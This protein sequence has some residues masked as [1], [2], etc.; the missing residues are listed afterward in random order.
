[1]GVDAIEVVYEYRK[2]SKVITK[3]IDASTK[4]EIIERTEV[5]YK[6]GERYTTTP[7]DKAEYIL[8]KEPTN[9]EGIVGRNDI[10][11]V[12]E[13]RKMSSGLI[14]KYIDYVSNEMLDEE[15]YEGNENDKIKL[16]I[17]EF[18]GYAIYIKP[19]KEEVSLT[20]TLQE[21]KIYYRK[22]VKLQII[23][24]DETTKEE[25][26]REEKEGIEGDTYKTEGREIGG[27]IL[28]REPDN[29]KGVYLRSKTEVI[30]GYRK[31]S[32]GVKVTYIDRE[33]GEI[34][35]EERINGLEGESYS[36]E[37]KEFDKYEYKDSEGNI[38]G[39]F[40]KELIEV[41]CYYEKKKGKVEVVYEDEEGNEIFKEELIG[42]VG[43][44]YKVEE[45]NIRN[46]SIKTRPEVTEGEYKVE[47]ITVKYI[48]TRLKGKVTVRI[49]DE[50][51][52]EL[53]RIEQ[54]GYAGDICYI[55]LP[56]YELYENTEEDQISI[57][58]T[59]SEIVIEVIYKKIEKQIKPV[60]PTNPSNPEKPNEPDRP[61]RRPYPLPDTSDINLWL[62]VKI[63]VISILVIALIVYIIRK[64]NK[65]KNKKTKK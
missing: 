60:D 15:I 21:V 62:Y 23:G 34:L 58:Y 19:N 27:Y 37:I 33:T 28:E 26:Y 51:G 35:G 1:M 7:Q 48:L 18:E 61:I 56:V 42:K 57:E 17:K 30:Y 63:F 36:V 2:T 49:I 6:E 14:V 32:E 41:K 16:D 8:T 45:K 55:R 3:Y 10:E 9:K 53:D 40:K 50:K 13:Y 43:E 44:R 54:E 24:I 22:K 38:E 5:T 29:K 59:D 47:K 11:V 46:Y 31:S 12:Y 64:V 25:L 4:K 39:K 20:V 65:S 52:K